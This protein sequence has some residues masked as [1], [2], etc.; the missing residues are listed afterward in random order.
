MESKT[1][2]LCDVLFRR[3]GPF[4]QAGTHLLWPGKCLI[5]R[6]CI[7]PADEGL[8]PSCWQDLAQAVGADYCR[9]CGRDVSPYG[10]IN[11][12]CGFCQEMEFAYDGIV[13]VGSYET[14]LRSMILALK[15]R[16]Q[17]EWIDRLSEMLRQTLI[18]SSF[19]PGIE[20][21]VPVPLH[22]LRRLKRGFNQSCLLAEKLHTLGIPIAADL[23]RIRNTEQQW[24]LTPAQRR[25]NVRGAFAVRKGHPFAGKTLALVDDIT[26]SGATLE[27]CA[28]T[29]K[30]AGASN[31]YAV[32]LATARPESV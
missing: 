6:E 1:K 3:I 31:V 15:F 9:R 5:C 8:C 23:V 24:D 11:G 17:T 14:S 20:L 30:Q 4:W 21:L 18:T 32:V 2:R 16:E 22:W 13:R 19:F 7:H 25:R 10:I 28:K 27:E 29:L 12:R 26:T